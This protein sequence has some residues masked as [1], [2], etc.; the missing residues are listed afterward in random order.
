MKRKLLKTTPT[1]RWMLTIQMVNERCHKFMKCECILEIY[2]VPLA[3]ESNAAIVALDTGNPWAT[4]PTI[5]S[6]PEEDNWANFSKADFDTMS[7]ATPM[8]IS[9]SPSTGKSV[10]YFS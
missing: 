1:I 10:N 3:I 6:E 9:D 4:A 8:E 7:S 5:A 2:F